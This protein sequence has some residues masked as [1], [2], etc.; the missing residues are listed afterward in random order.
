MTVT[1]LCEILM[2]LKERGYGND[3]VHCDADGFVENVIAKDYD[4]SWDHG[5]AT[6]PPHAIVTL[7]T[8]VVDTKEEGVRIL[9]YDWVCSQCGDSGYGF[10]ACQALLDYGD[11]RSDA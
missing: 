11:D 7:S 8:S 10:H 5:E 9:P 3:P 4:P 6:N 2:D 1:E